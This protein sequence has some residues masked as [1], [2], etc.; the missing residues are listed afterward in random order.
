MAGDEPTDLIKVKTVYTLN[1]AIE[2]MK[3]NDN[4]PINIDKSPI[5]WVDVKTGKQVVIGYNY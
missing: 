5:S 2:Y 1:E 3:R 4:Q